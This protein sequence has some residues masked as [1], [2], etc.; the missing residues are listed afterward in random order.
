[1][2]Y[3]SYIFLDCFNMFFLLQAYFLRTYGNE[4]ILVLGKLPSYFLY[5]IIVGIFEGNKVI[6]ES[7]NKHPTKT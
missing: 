6:K 7:V 1:M 5:P 4:T 3:I 2:I